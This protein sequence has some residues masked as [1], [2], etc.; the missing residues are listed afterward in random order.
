MPQSSPSLQRQVRNSGQPAASVLPDADRMRNSAQVDIVVP[1]TS[2]Q[3]DLALSI[4]RLHSF[5]TGQLPFTARVTIACGA[6]ND[7][8]WQTARALAAT[9][10]E[11][12]AVRVDAPGRGAALRTVWPGS[13]CD[14]L[15]YLDPDLSIDLSALIPLIEP[16][17]S[18]RA[19]VAI[20]TRL[21][22]GAPPQG[23][24]RREVTSCGYSLL[25]QAG[26]GTGF[27]DAQ[28]GFKAITRD[29]ATRLLPQTT[30]G[31]WFFDA[32]VLTLAE[33]AGLRIH[34]VPVNQA[35]GQDA[36]PGTRPDRRRAGVRWRP[37]R[38]RSYGY[39]GN[40]A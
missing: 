12:T 3:R 32:E 17:L 2:R 4:I 35:G 11:V 26:L 36:R 22:P 15:A 13:D 29:C 8:G 39:R 14:V 7:G 31:G 25:L 5:L 40:A 30:Q 37:N 6:G 1:V 24:P 23:S 21:A 16:L 34:E 9:F 33:R 27:A 38:R 19:D 20:G 10:P 18:G 28:C